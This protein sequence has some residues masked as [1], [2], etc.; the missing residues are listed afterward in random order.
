LVE[1][2]EI[3]LERQLVAKL[4]IT[5]NIC[6]EWMLASLWMQGEAA[7]MLKFMRG[8]SAG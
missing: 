7:L 3:E 8:K 1:L 5:R 6:I 4:Q 2:S